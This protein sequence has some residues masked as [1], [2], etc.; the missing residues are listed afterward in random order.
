MSVPL[1]IE[2]IKAILTD[3]ELVTSWHVLLADE[4]GNRALYKF[5][6]QLLRPAYRLEIRLIQIEEELLY[7]YQLF[8]D[9]PVIR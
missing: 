6:C 8:T 3:S 4:A 5:R 7:S 1:D 9:Q 2:Q